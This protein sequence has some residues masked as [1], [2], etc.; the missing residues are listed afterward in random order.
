MTQTILV[1]DDDPNARDIYST[2]LREVGYRVIAGSDGR[3]AIRLAMRHR[4]DLIILDLEMPR[5]DGWHA[6]EGLRSNPGTRDT[7]ILALTIVAKGEDRRDPVG[8]GFDSHYVKP[9][10]PNRLVEIAREWVGQPGHTLDPDQ[11]LEASK[12]SLRRSRMIRRALMLVSLAIMLAALLLPLPVRVS[13]AGGVMGLLFFQ[14]VF[15]G[16]LDRFITGKRQYPALRAEVDRLL[17]LVRELNSAAVEARRDRDEQEHRVRRLVDAL[18]EA[19]DQ[20]PAVAG[21]TTDD[22]PRAVH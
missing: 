8:R 21:V 3:E 18:H 1:V 12:A 20:L 4:P 14:V 5:F 9:I 16:G 7:P 2:I 11:P 15:W 22:P 17:V 10:P 19:V 6:L 13:I